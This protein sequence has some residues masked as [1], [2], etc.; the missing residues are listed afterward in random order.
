MH[1]FVLKLSVS[2]A[3][4]TTLIQ[5]AVKI[6][7]GIKK[8]GNNY[9]PEGIEVSDFVN[10]FKDSVVTVIEL[11]DFNLEKLDCEFRVPIV[12]QNLAS[13][14][15]TSQPSNDRKHILGQTNIFF[16]PPTIHD[17]VQILLRFYFSEYLP[18]HPSDTS[19]REIIYI[20]PNTNERTVNLH[21]AS[22]VLLV[23][24]KTELF[25]NEMYAGILSE[26]YTS[27]MKVFYVCKYCEFERRTLFP[28]QKFT[29][30]GLRNKAEEVAQGGIN[31]IWSTSLSAARY[32]KIVP[33]VNELKLRDVVKN[34]DKHLTLDTYM[35]TLILIRSRWL[36]RKITKWFDT[37]SYPTISTEITPYPDPYSH[38]VIFEMGSYNFITCNGVFQT[39]L[40]FGAY[41]NPF[42]KYSWISIASTLIIVPLV[43]SVTL[44]YLR[45]VPI[46]LSFWLIF[47]ALIFTLINQYP[48]GNG[49][50][51]RCKDFR[52][53]FRAGWGT[54]L[55]VAVVLVNAYVY[56]FN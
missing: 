15:L 4:K 41:L 35:L 37:P 52:F 33:F 28:I 45:N 26:D 48:R 29:P 24:E 39:N 27:L 30:S 12:L 34:A 50:N 42:D 51:I 3:Y 23:N 54:F 17:N 43:S 18:F 44:Y 56:N 13:S 16:L 10:N 19:F 1:C 11:W 55:V 46:S 5:N 6:S 53:I 31:Y 47:E 25:A 38:R 9:F 49:R 32:E 8:E 40:N 7:R 22:N 20:F 14:N 36:N 21:F 2:E